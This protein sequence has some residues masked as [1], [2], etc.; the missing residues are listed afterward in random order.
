MNC[1]NEVYPNDT[2]R[3]CFT[4]VININL[5]MF[6]SKIDLMKQLLNNSLNTMFSVLILSLFH[7]VAG[8]YTYVG[9]MRSGVRK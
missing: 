6:Q 2:I 3:M 8:F 7:D 5:E 1:R 9:S 4:R